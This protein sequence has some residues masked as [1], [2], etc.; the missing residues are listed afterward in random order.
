MR[1]GRFRA[2]SDETPGRKPARNASGGSENPLGKTFVG[3]RKARSRPTETK[4]FVMA[5]PTCQRRR[6]LH[7][8][9]FLSIARSHKQKTEI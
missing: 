5:T 2:S 4:Q 7:G 8:F 6:N 3:T 9:R 1:P